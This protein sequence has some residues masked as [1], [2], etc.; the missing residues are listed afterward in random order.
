MNSTEVSTEESVICKEVIINAPASKVWKALTEKEQIDKW[1][2][3]P[4]N[5]RAEA[6]TTFH[7]TGTKDGKEFPHTCTILEIIP[8]K[9]L[10]YTW[11]MT[12]ID[13]ETIVSW[14]LEEKGTA[15]KLTLTHS[16]WDKVKFHTTDLSHSDF[17]N[18]WNH[19]TNKLKEYSE[20][21]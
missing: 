19:F 12:A 16:Q 14:E 15:T 17:V 7:M 1:F 20:N 8:E 6:G 2:M 5:F 11:N 13:G 9:K 18:G 4:D 10:T 3:K 21:L